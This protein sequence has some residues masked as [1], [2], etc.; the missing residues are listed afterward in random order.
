MKKRIISLFLAAVMTLGLVACGGS[1]ESTTE[2]SSDAEVK[3]TFTY[4]IQ[5]DTGNTLNYFTTDTR[6]GMS[7]IKMINEPL[8]TLAADGSYNFYAAESFETEDGLTYTC[9]LKEGALWSDSDDLTADDVLFTFAEYAKT[10]ESF[11]AEVKKVDDTTVEFVLASP[12]A[13]FPETVSNVNLLPSHIFEGKD[14]LDMNMTEDTIVGCGPYMFDSYESGQYLKA[15]KNPNYV[16]GEANIDTVIYQIITDNATAKAALQNGEV[17]AWVAS[18]AELDGLED[19]TITPYSEGRVAYVRLSRVSENM[20]DK[21]YRTGILKALNREEIMIA[22]YSSLDYATISYSFLPATN[23]YYTEDVEK[24]D[25]DIEA[26]KELVAGGAITLKICYIGVD[27][28]QTAQ[29]QV[30]QAQLKEI[31]IEVELCGV[32]QAA[33]VESAYDNEDTTYD[34]Y[35]GGYIMTIDPDGYKG[36]FGTGNMI[37]YANPELDALFEAGMLETDPVKRAE[38]YTEAQQMVADEA[39]FYPFG[40]NLRIIVT[41]PALQG[42]EEA[43]LA[44]IYTF[45]DMSKLHY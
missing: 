41:N 22:A 39:L 8:F 29:A 19:F 32:E 28:A 14:S 7:F 43:T 15:V 11:T 38:I 21:D 17:D 10:D 45:E 1:E 33:Y 23:G 44:P 42:I 12:I 5:S 16:N 25:Q 30:I 40:T 24:Y 9:K 4:A 6:E 34:M 26:A 20:Q 2:G 3:E 37:N 18:A 31:G 27:P 13:S 36:M 35:L